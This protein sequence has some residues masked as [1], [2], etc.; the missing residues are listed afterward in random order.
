MPE[1]RLLIVRFSS[2]GDIAQCL[3]AAD[4]FKD[5]YPKGRVTWV[6]RSD[7]AEFLKLSPNVDHIVAF[8]RVAGV[9]GLV[10]LARRLAAESFTHLYDAHSNLRSHLLVGA[11]RLFNLLALRSSPQLLR[12]SKMRWRRFLFF[13]F[14]MA[15]L[16]KPFRG[17]ES[18]LK[19][20]EAWWPAQD[21]PPPPQIEG[22]GERAAR[23]LDLPPEFIL[24]APS[25]AWE[26]KRWPPSHFKKLVELLPH[27]HFILV[28]GPQD[29]FLK[30]IATVAP[31]RVKNLAGQLS[32]RESTQLIAKAQLV[33]SNDTGTLHIADWLGQKCLALIGPTAFGY[34][35]R[36]TSA[37][38]EIELSCKPCSK[39]GRGGCKNAMYKRCLEEI[40]PERVAA[41][42]EDALR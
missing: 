3:S 6:V 30:E 8:S 20:L 31:S 15:V 37:T 2:L 13:N 18:F 25:A 40:E 16:P 34:P 11:I 12:R 24:L 19:P 5:L 7:F 38:L 1:P 42:I 36:P 22:L 29:L 23:R 41:A 10:S 32:W 14:R 33:V 39:D 26:M 35:S 4:R 27:R 17:M 28:G 21:L 9:E